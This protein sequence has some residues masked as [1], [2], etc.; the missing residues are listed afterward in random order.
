MRKLE[1]P[2]GGANR[3]Y[4]RGSLGEDA[5]FRFKALLPLGRPAFLAQFD[6][7][8]ADSRDL[9]RVGRRCHFGAARPRPSRCRSHGHGT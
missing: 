7:P 5:V 8:Q 3:G 4:S 9:R 6:L 1:R 2:E